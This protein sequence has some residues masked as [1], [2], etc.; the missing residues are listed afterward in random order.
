MHEYSLQALDEKALTVVKSQGEYPWQQRTING[1]VIE[2]QRE[3]VG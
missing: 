3:R 2:G 1:E